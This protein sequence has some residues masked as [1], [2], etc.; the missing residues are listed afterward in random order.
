M[1]RRIDLLTCVLAANDR[2]FMSGA[3]SLGAGRLVVLP[4]VVGTDTREPDVVAFGAN[5]WWASAMQG[6]GRDAVAIVHSTRQGTPLFFNAPPSDADIRATVLHPEVDGRFAM[7]AEHAK[8]PGEPIV[9]VRARL[10]EVRNGLPTR[11][12]GE[13]TFQRLRD[14]DL[15]LASTVF[16]VLVRVGTRMGHRPVH[17]DWRTA[18]E[19]NAPGSVVHLLRVLGLCDLAARG[20]EPRAGAAGLRS[21]VAALQAAPRMRPA[22][23]LFPLA[24]SVAARDPSVGEIMLTSAWRDAVEAVGGAVPEQWRAVPERIRGRA[25]LRT[26]SAH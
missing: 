2:G 14:P 25:P 6:L 16:E 20:L 4:P 10:F 13:W 21:L 9:I 23:E 12:L 17:R 15:D 5:A 18:F 1:V 22:L 26:V 7:L 24:M 3:G 8:R 19:A 11:P